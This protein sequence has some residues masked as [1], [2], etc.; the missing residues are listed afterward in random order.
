MSQ[1]INPNWTPV[2]VDDLDRIF[3]RAQDETGKWI[4][5]DAKEATDTQFDIWIRTRIQI[6]GGT[7]PWSLEERADV[8]NRLWQRHELVMMRKDISDE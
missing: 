2:T 5:V 1:N 8:C 7:E 4:R 3:F 6:E